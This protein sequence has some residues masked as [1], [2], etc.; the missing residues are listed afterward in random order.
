MIKRFKFKNK[1]FKKNTIKELIY[2]SFINYGKTR[3][4]YLIDEL[5]DLGYYYATK[6]GLSISVEDLNIPKKKN[7]FIDKSKHCVLFTKLAYKRGELNFI[8]QSNTILNSWARTTN[9]LTQAIVA[10]LQKFDPFNSLHLMVFSGA[11]GNISQVTQLMG[12]RGLMS[13]S[14]GQLME[15]PIIHNFREGLTIIDY[16]MSTYGSRKGI[17]D[18]ALKT[19]DAGYLTRRLVN[20]VNDII[21]RDI[22]CSTT[23]FIKIYKSPLKSNF[24]NQLLGRTSVISIYDF[25]K[26]KFI[27]YKNTCITE[28]I[29]NNLYSCALYYICVYSIL[30]CKLENSICKKC[31]GWDIA[32][33]KP[34]KLGDAVGVIAAQSIGEPG[35]QLTMR[36]FHT[37]GSFSLSTS[38]QIIAKFTGV[39]TYADNLYIKKFRTQN[40]NIAKKILKPITLKLISYQNNINNILLNFG[41]ILYVFNKQF[42]LKQTLIAEI[43]IREKVQRVTSIKSIRASHSGELLLLPQINLIALLKGNVYDFPNTSFLNNFSSL[44]SFIKPYFIF[45]FKIYALVSGFLNYSFKLDILQDTKIITEMHIFIFP[46]FWDKLLEKIIFLGNYK[47]FFILEHIPFFLNKQIY[48]FSK[49]KTLLYDSK[50]T[51]SLSYKMPLLNSVNNLSLNII[52]SNLILLYIPC[53]YIFL[54]KINSKN[55]I[56]NNSKSQ[57]I[58]NISSQIKGFLNSFTTILKTYNTIK[59]GTLLKYSV[60]MFT[61]LGF[62][63]DFNNKIFFPGEFIK[64]IEI[65]FLTKIEI[66]KIKIFFYILLRPLTCINIVKNKSFKKFGYLNLI[67][68]SQT[69]FI[70]N[71]KKLSSFIYDGQ[72]LSLVKLTLWIKAKTS[73]L[74][75]SNI[76]CFNNF[77]Y[78][79]FTSYLLNTIK[80]NLLLKTHFPIKDRFYK[81]QLSNNEYLFKNTII[82]LFSS[83]FKNFGKYKTLKKKLTITPRILVFNQNN[84]F[85]YYFETIKQIKKI[86][87]YVKW[88]TYLVPFVKLFL[89]G[90]I[91]FGDTFSLDIHSSTSFF[92]S[93]N[94]QIFN[95]S[96]NY[97]KYGEILGFIYFDQI[98]TSDIVQGLP[99]LEELLELQSTNTSLLYSYNSGL[100]IAINAQN[101][102]NFIKIKGI[103]NYLNCISKFTNFF[104]AKK[105]VLETLYLKPY[106]FVYIGQILTFS[107][108]NFKIL[109][110][111]IFLSLLR[112]Q[113]LF[114]AIYSSF[115]RIQIILIKKI[116]LV[117]S[118][119]NVL[120]SMKHLEVIVRQLT[121]YIKIIYDNSNSFLVGEI[122]KLTYLTNINLIFR[123]CKKDYIYYEPIIMGITKIS[124]QTNSFLSIVSFQQTLKNLAIAAIEG[125]IDWFFGLKE[126]I[127]IGQKTSIGEHY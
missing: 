105:S 114:N 125:K 98:V 22:D 106:D 42:I 12:M 97:I 89:N 104:P 103:N 74:Y 113:I 86:Y 53:E 116:K 107:S 61:L 87:S 52:N 79:Q 33:Q 82:N 126:N 91:S 44:K 26:K 67:L 6:S 118:K 127:M 111:I 23:Y 20:S 54:K 63:V 19:A 78:L 71:F 21:I 29:A 30:T 51:G 41:S 17:V 84:Y 95:F 102:T 100:I 66:T 9:I 15:I 119:Q 76:Y 27:V 3:T 1:I 48:I 109:L 92:I 50:F 68:I 37:G 123:L 55:L 7:E 28:K 57:I 88:N 47:K 112:W 69:Y 70:P 81:L 39:V 34:I 14:N 110:N 5:K 10:L 58:H 65:T 24:I 59:P 64:N 117:Y 101:A 80:T 56:L 73:F 18:T 45:Y 94:T 96:K 62:T 115:K 72:S 16:I 93:D 25:T 8:E 75:L 32:L 122:I 108:I 11:R 4:S 43:M 83:K 46:I 99:K 90:K 121:S 13:D 36:T 120:V 49:Q 60:S 40:G 124:L 31:Y 38:R 2:E 35:T 85:N 77:K